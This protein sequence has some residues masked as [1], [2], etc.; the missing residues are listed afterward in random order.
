[1][2]AHRIGAD[3]HKALAAHSVQLSDTDAETIR[4]TQS[5][6]VVKISTGGAETRTVADP[7]SRRSERAT[8][9]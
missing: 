6:A 9:L 1:M 2:T 7:T 8:M 4:V 3:G 5:P